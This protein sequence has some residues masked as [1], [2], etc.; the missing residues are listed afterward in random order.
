MVELFEHL[1][2][3][4]HNP[5]PQGNRVAI[6]TNAGGPGVMTTDECIAHG[7]ILAPINTKME[8]AL[9]KEL[10][11]SA[12]WHNPIDILG[13]ARSDRYYRTLK[14]LAGDKDIDSLLVILTPQS[15]TDEEKIA[16]AIIETKQ[17]YKKPMVVSFIGGKMVTEGVTTLQSAGIATVNFPEQGA[18][19]LAALTKFSEHAK[20]PKHDQTISIKNTNSKKVDQIFKAASAAG[21]KSFPEAE[22]MR[23]L[24]AYDFPLV[25]SH[26]IQNSAEAKDAIKYV[27]GL[28]VLKV[29]SP[30]IL[31]KSEVGG[32]IL[33]VT[34]ENAAEKMAELHYNIKKNAP[35]A[36]IEGFLVTEMI[37][38]YGI[39]FILGA[40]REPGL[41]T[42]IMVGLGGIYVEV[43]HDVAFGVNPLTTNDIEHM[44]GKLKSEKILNGTRGKEP[45]DRKALVECIARLSKLLID[46]PQIKELDINPL[47]VTGKG[48]KVLDA[49]IIIE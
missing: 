7:L 39:E 33:N 27:G 32:V 47:M 46:F 30:E 16:E 31:H 28:G 29:I 40:N 34:P 10:P 19:A 43:F 37:S 49:R 9:K 6:I 2:V 21:K 14:V 45:L 44:I 15:M 38:E 17:N 42:M 12:N 11:P 18:R 35:K 26:I 48:V 13:D 24:S 1:R 23:I 36:Q 25:K 20:N 5:L 4:T 3:F 22:A 41:G 8:V